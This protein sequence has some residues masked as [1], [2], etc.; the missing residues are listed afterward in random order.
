V[1][2]IDSMAPRKLSDSD[3]GD[4]IE[5]YKQPNQTTSTLAE[6]YGVSNST[7]SRILKT[8]LAPADYSE[9][10]S[11]KRMAGSDKTEAPAKTKQTRG[12]SVKSAPIESAPE[13]I[14][15]ESTPAYGLAAEPTPIEIPPLEAS[16]LADES[17]DD[18][19]KVARPKLKTA[20][21]RDAAKSAGTSRRRRKGSRSRDDDDEQLPLLGEGMSG[22]GMSGEGISG[23]GIPGELLEVAV[24]AAKKGAKRRTSRTEAD[25]DLDDDDD[26]LLGLDE[27]LGDDFGDDDDLDDD[28]DED[29]DDDSL[30]FSIP[31]L[32]PLTA[33]EIM[34]LG[35]AV[36]P[37]PCYLVV[38]MRSE[39]IT[40]PLS[41]FASLG[42]IPSDEEKAKTLPVF[43]NH[44][45]ARRFSRN[46]QRVI[47]VPDGNLITRTSP[48]LQAKGITRLLVDGQIFDLVER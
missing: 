23:E 24:S 15:T 3:K 11:Q 46:K 16:R 41:D 47:K 20:A 45:V 35:E 14:P 32:Q 38:D 7:I 6:Q 1:K 44:R 37:K 31:K 26:D 8:T 25:D 9:L 4:I 34:P 40:R 30:D 19:A 17:S 5:L 10:I 18:S 27:T 12:T 13:S 2:D 39:L 28:D 21:E 36:L 43:D 33:M 29:D 22:E 42:Q 48:Y